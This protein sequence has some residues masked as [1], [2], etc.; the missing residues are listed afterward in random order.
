M[1]IPQTKEKKFK[2]GCLLV[3]L[4]IVLQSDYNKINEIHVNP[5]SPLRCARIHQDK[6]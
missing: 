1:K 2:F 4:F 3:A 6:P 5:K